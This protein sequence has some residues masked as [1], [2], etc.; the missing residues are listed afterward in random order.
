MCIIDFE[1]LSYIVITRT[2]YVSSMESA[3]PNHK[4]DDE[5]VN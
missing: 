1:K 4:K 2:W 3:Y 5:L